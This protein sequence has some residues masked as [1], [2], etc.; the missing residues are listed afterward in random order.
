MPFSECVCIPGVPSLSQPEL[1]MQSCMKLVHSL[2]FSKWDPRDT[3]TAPNAW[4]GDL[5]LVWF[6]QTIERVYRPHAIL[7]YGFRT[8]SRRYWAKDPKTKGYFATN[9]A[10]AT[11]DR[12]LGNCLASKIAATQVYSLIY[13][14]C[15]CQGYSSLQ[16][17]YWSE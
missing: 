10:I 5:G 9:N 7:C 4:T 6:G 12:I 3:K 17:T 15:D 13:L 16:S 1:Q 2:K 8:E 11:V 14:Y